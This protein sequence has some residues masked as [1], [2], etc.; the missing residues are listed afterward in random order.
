VL[1]AQPALYSI[2]GLPGVRK[3]QGLH[4]DRLGVDIHVLLADG[5][6]LRNI[7]H[8]V[9][10]A[11]LNVRSIVASPIATGIA[12]LTSEERELGVALIELGAEVTNV[13]LFV[14]G[15]LVGL[16][17]LPYGASDITDDIASAYG[18]QRAQAERLKCFYGS[19]ISSPRDNHDVIELDDY[20]TGS[21]RALERI[22]R[23]QLV[24]TI[25]QRLD[26][27]IGQIGETLKAMGFVGPGRRQIVLTGGGA[28]LKGLADFVE[29]ALGQNARLGKPAGIAALPE[30]HSG[31]AFSTLAG[32]VIYADQNPADL[33]QLGGGL[34]QVH[35]FAGSSLLARLWNALRTSF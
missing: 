3:P 9:R 30:A 27:L 10:S 4:A 35:R 11:H 2:D 16:H 15:M 22:T 6:P 29:A 28:E 1:H 8:A 18:L 32:L 5:S 23:A 21:S 14:G 20:G 33:R 26:H 13:S 34:Q 19:A 24:A 12:C 7:S 25:R 31:T 17:A